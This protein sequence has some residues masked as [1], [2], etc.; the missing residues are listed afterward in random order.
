MLPFQDKDRRIQHG[1]A[2]HCWDEQLRSDT[3]VMGSST[4]DVAVTGRAVPCVRSA[5]DRHAVNWNS[6]I[7]HMEDLPTLHSHRIHHIQHIPTLETSPQAGRTD[8]RPCD[9]MGWEDPDL[10]QGQ[11][12]GQS[13]TIHDPSLSLLA[14]GNCRKWD[15][16]KR[17]IKG[18]AAN[19]C[20]R[21]RRGEMSAVD[22][23]WRGK[24]SRAATS[25]CLRG[26]GGGRGDDMDGIGIRAVIPSSSQ[27]Q[28]LLI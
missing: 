3:P 5:Q 1:I 4:M 24:V 23:K 12:H 6:L 26:I 2:L 13:S 18:R 22:V 28:T 10:K 17:W 7:R 27:S 9:G 19:E 20:S 11:C 8:V 15:M 25:S 16:K 14:R 21:G